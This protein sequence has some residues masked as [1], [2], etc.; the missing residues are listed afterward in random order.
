MA[1]VSRQIDVSFKLHKGT[2]AGTNSDTKTYSGLRCEASINNTG[3][4]SLNS[5]QFRVYGMSEQTMN[6][7]STFGVLVMDTERNVITVTASNSKGG[8][9]Q[10]FQG[11]IAQAWTDYRGMPEASF[12]VEAYA[13]FYEQIKAI[14]VNSYDGATDVATVIKSLAESIGFSFTNNGVTTKL[15]SPYFA[16]SAVTQIKTC[17]EHAGIAYDISNGSVQI[18]PSGESR[19]DV[20]FLISPDTGLV[21]YP[22]FSNIG[23]GI[24]TLFNPDIILGR[25]L[26]VKSS[27]PRACRDDW[28]C[29]L[30]NHELA[31]QV[32][33]GPWFTYAQLAPKGWY[34]AK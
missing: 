1:F 20:T 32:P 34:V 24:Q 10:V 6:D 8:M 29:K 27:I 21:G 25:K 30:V 33:N 19:D 5:L 28:Y 13:G 26:Q 17:A 9:S 11:T 2:F 16:G 22:T 12:N 18:W 3:G 15:E 23:I 4:A 14:A 31:S 7:I